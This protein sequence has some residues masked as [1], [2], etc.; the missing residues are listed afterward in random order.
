MAEGAVRPRPVFKSRERLTP[1]AAHKRFDRVC[2]GSGLSA[3]A[4]VVCRRASACISGAPDVISGFGNWT[5]AVCEKPGSSANNARP[6]NPTHFSQNKEREK[7]RM[8]IPLATRSWHACLQ[9]RADRGKRNQKLQFK[10]SSPIVER[11]SLRQE[12]QRLQRRDLERL[13]APDICARQLVVPSYHVRLS[14]GEPRPVPF[15]RSTGQLS[16]LAPHNPCHFVL[17]RLP[18][19]GAVN[20]MRPL[21]SSFVEKLTLFHVSLAPSLLFGNDG[22]THILPDWGT[23][24]LPLRHNLFHT[25][26]CHDE[27]QAN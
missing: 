21:L 5:A 10:R 27:T 8:E 7:I 13:A 26:L 9:A 16:P 2:S 25:R 15:I 4:R 14:L 19:L 1:N 17:A 24:P 20:G 12:R 11:G 23:P 18:A 3:K 6:A 22:P